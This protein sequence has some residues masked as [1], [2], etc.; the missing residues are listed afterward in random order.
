MRAHDAAYLALHLA[1]EF[2]RS[3]RYGHYLSVLECHVHG[4]REARERLGQDAVDRWLNEFVS[5]AWG[6]IRHGDWVARSGD[7]GFFFV[8]PETNVEG[9]HVVADKLRRLIARQPLV[10][11]AVLIE[12][13]L[14]VGVTAMEAYSDPN[15]AHRLSALF[16]RLDSTERSVEALE[17]D[18]VRYPLNCASGSE[19]VLDAYTHADE[20]T[21]GR[22]P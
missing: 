7:E 9:A 18:C 16:R 4:L 10:T 13:S 20:N 17:G 8:L 2:A 3:L 12:F 19:A 14:K 22:R 15:C 1:R 11:A 21:G 5:L 6:C